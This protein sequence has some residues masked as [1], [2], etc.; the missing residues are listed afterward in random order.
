MLISFALPRPVSAALL[1]ALTLTSTACAPWFTRQVAPQEAPPESPVVPV[2]AGPRASETEARARYAQASA[3]AA[4]TTTL[5]GAWAGVDA[6]LE[7][8]RVALV[9]KEWNTAQREADEAVAGAE[10]TLSDHYARLANAELEKSYRY[11][12][13]D[14]A[15]LLQLR[16][17]EEILITGNSRLAYGRLRMLN[18]QLQ[19]R[20][21]SY[22]V[23]AGD[24]L[25]VIA[26]RPEVYSNGL[27]WPLVWQNNAVQIPDPNRLRRGQ[28]LKLKLHPSADEIAE[29]VD[30]A[31]GQRQRTRGVTPSI[32]EIREVR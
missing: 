4:Q 23:Q 1:M 30:Y 5:V 28:V 21:R 11:A 25:W 18:E 6:H 19:K 27:L 22:T 10:Q 31:R 20:I 8:S 13:L 9:A 17:A 24:S 12:G 15:Q 14:D 29:A 7:A 26:A 16:A 3:I 2:A 32:G